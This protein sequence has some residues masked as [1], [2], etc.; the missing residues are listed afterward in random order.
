MCQHRGDHESNACVVLTRCSQSCEPF[1]TLDI[2]AASIV[3]RYLGRLPIRL[4]KRRR[5][6]SWRWV[7]GIVIGLFEMLSPREARGVQSA[8]LSGDADSENNH[9]GSQG[10]SIQTIRELSRGFSKP[11]VRLAARTFY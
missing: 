8:E 10:L 4:L 1:C 6:R 5:Q 2:R 11:S 3:N 7:D 9:G